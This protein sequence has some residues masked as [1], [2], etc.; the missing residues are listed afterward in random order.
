MDPKLLIALGLLFAAS[1]GVSAHDSDRIE[2]LESE[3]QALEQRLSELESKLGQETSDAESV[4]EDEGWKSIANWRK[5][6]AGMS[7]LSVKKILGD[8][9]KIDGAK[10]AV[11]YYDNGGMVWVVDGNVDRWMEP[12]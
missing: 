5:L 1:F 6:G 2:Q 4:T 8:P 3:L 11:W 12:E 7:E 9:H 10:N